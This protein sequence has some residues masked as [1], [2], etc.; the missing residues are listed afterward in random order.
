MIDGAEQFGFGDLR[1]GGSWLS[2]GRR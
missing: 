1:N 2:P